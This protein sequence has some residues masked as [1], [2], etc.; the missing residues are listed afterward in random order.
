MAGLAVGVAGAAG[1]GHDVTVLVR[2]TPFGGSIASTAFTVTLGATDLVANFY[3]ASVRVNTG[4]RIHVQVS[5]TGGNGNIAK[6]IKNNLSLPN[7]EITNLSRNDLNVLNQFD[8]EKY[9][10]ENTFDILVHTAI[11]GG[12]RTKEENGDVTHNNL[13]ML[14]NLLKFADRFK[15]IINFDSAA[16]YDRSSDI[17]NRKETDIYTI[18][19][20]YYGFSKYVIYQRS[21]QYNN[22]YNFRIFNIFHKNEEHDRFI[23]SCFNAKKNNTQVTIFEDKYFDK[24]RDKFPDFTYYESMMDFALAHD[25]TTIPYY[26]KN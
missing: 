19:T 21:L 14:E 16:I 1:T 18:P 22:M 4:D 15:M 11:L 9:L 12:R 8:I 3:N 7:Y 17:L 13:I 24:I 26:L 20:D 23:K 5:Y 2:V 6:M 25:L 10:N